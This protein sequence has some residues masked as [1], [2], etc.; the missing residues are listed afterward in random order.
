[1][2]FKWGQT[3]WYK[4]A[5]SVRQRDGTSKAFWLEGPRVGMLGCFQVLQLRSSD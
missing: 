2:I 4:F 3:Y 1:M 5:W